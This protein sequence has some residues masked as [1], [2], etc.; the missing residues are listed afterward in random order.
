MT[1]PLDQSEV[2][3]LMAAIQDGRVAAEPGGDARGPVMSYDLT[4]QD[5]IIRGQMPT[6]DSINERIASV[7]GSNLGARTRLD[8]RAAPNASTLMKFSDVGGLFGPANSVWIVTLGPGHGMAVLM[9]EASLGRAL[10][11]GALGDRK[12][13]PDVGMTDVRQEL[14][15]VERRVLKNLL[16]MF[17]EAMAVCWA[18]VLA[19]KPEVIRFE[20]DPRMA[21]VAPPTDLAILC[22]YEISGA[23]AGRLQIAIPYATVEPVK[24]SLTQPPRQGNS[25]DARFAAALT[26]E[27]EK[28]RVQVRVEMGRARINFSRLLELKVGDLL[29]LDGSE[30]TPLPVYVQG[31]RKMTGIP[32]VVGGSMAVVIDRGLREQRATSRSP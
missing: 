9:V 10:I 31:R 8:L 17:C 6:L 11:S 32:R 22:S 21:M 19:F 14:T 25:V 16:G 7:F 15:N 12:A 5:R 26:K 18:E 29:V 20:S 4:S 3:A 28:V 24:K 1:S 30:A 13:R 23:A 2:D 27:I